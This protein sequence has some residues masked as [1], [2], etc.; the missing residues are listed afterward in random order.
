MS[1]YNVI[2]QCVFSYEYKY[3]LFVKSL[4]LYFFLVHT[5]PTT[6]SRAKKI[7]ILAWMYEI[8]TTMVGIIHLE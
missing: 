8:R 1:N 7:I 4:Y 3:F 5:K 6:S 2:S